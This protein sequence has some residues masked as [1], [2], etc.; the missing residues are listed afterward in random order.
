MNSITDG[1]IF[2]QILNG[3]NDAFFPQQLN[4]D[5]AGKS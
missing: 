5:R 3:R 1:E 2:Y 4:E